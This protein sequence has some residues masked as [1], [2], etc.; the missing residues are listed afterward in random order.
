MSTENNVAVDSAALVRN[1]LNGANFEE[2][3]EQLKEVAKNKKKKSASPRKVAKKVSE[4]D[5]ERK[6]TGTDIEI[7][8]RIKN[9][10]MNV[11]IN[12][13]FNGHDIPYKEQLWG[14]PRRDVQH[15]LR[16]CRSF[17][18][19]SD[20]AKIM[21]GVNKLTEEQENS[22]RS[23]EVAYFTINANETVAYS[24]DTL[25]YA[26]CYINR[27]NKLITDVKLVGSYL[28]D[29]NIDKNRDK[30]ASDI[31]SKISQKFMEN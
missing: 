25:G 24:R 31:K 9:L 13:T 26:K 1:M 3:Q 29:N 15:E 27:D 17:K 30:I 16:L 28:S 5:K 11:K 10:N 19:A 21:L 8:D 7:D 14:I 20:V 6:R 18:R 2:T 22:I 23:G 12:V 4:E